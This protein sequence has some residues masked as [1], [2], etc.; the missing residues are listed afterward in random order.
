MK[1]DFVIQIVQLGQYG[2]KSANM[3][4]FFSYWPTLIRPTLVF[5]ILSRFYI[6]IDH[7]IETL[8]H[9]RLMRQSGKKAK[10]IKQVKLFH[11]KS[12]CNDTKQSLSN[13][14]AC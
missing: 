9:C 13:H 11:L 4:F 8:C 2:T 3:D 10:K 14:C 12:K 7:E 5:Q 1:T 6:R